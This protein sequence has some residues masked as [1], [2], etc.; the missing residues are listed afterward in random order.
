MSQLATVSNCSGGRFCTAAGQT[1]AYGNQYLVQ[2]NNVYPPLNANSIVTVAVFSEYDTGTAIQQMAVTNT[3]GM[4]A[5]KPDA[6]WFSRYT[7]SNPQAGANQQVYIA[8]YL[9]GNDP[10]PVSDMLQLQLTATPAQYAQI[11]QILHP[12]PTPTA[13]AAPSPAR[14]SAAMGTM[15]SPAASATV[16]PGHATGTTTVT[17]SSSGHGDAGPAGRSGLS[18]G[19]IVGI[20]VGS[21]VGL[22]LVALLVLVPMYRRR[23]R[24]RRV[25]AKAAEMGGAGAADGVGPPGGGSDSAAAAAVA[26]GA[27]LG[28]AA[29]ALG[30][31]GAALLEKGRPG[32]ASPSDTPLLLGGRPNNSFTSREDSMMMMTTAAAAAGGDAQSPRAT[33]QPLNLDSPRV[34]V[35]MPPSTRSVARPADDAAAAAPVASPERILTTDDARQIGDLFRTAL[36][37]PPPVS[38]DGASDGA[39]G[40][41]SMLLHM[42]DDDDPLE[43]DDDPGWRER[44]ANERMQRELEQ[45]ASIIRS[46][47]MRA[48]GSDYSSS[49]PGTSQSERNS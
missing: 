39:G 49:R 13:T 46:V 27:A 48:H 6:S 16:S 9:Q 21:A 41:E 3:N 36:R 37:Q 26:A 10:P 18:T 17:I 28:P 40:R 15:S 11:Q 31:A 45:E 20:A 24:R 1:V 47:A 43:D 33:Y 42:D 34:L 23:V 32:S 4:V 22:L 14:T 38:E 35:N 8:V 19:A 25:L 12:S 29:L 7:G 2:W 44:V 30:G 5:L